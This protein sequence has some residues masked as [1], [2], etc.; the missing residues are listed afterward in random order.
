[1]TSFDPEALYTAGTIV[2]CGVMHLYFLW[3]G[4]LV[5]SGQAEDELEFLQRG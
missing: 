1:M 5:L 4:G 3:W 2:F